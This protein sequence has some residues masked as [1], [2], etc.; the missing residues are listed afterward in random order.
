MEGGMIWYS[1][2]KRT[3]I[4]TMM[5]LMV[6]LT[7]HSATAAQNGHIYSHAHSKEQ[8]KPEVQLLN[9]SARATKPGMSSSA[10]YMTI[11]NGTHEAIQIRSLSSP[12]AAKT[13]LHTTEM[14]NGMMKMRR[15]DNLTIKPGDKLELK[16]GGYHVML[17][18][19]KKPIATNSEVPVTITFSNGDKKTVVAHATDEIKGQH[20]A[21]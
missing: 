2:I 10:A 8:S 7:A 16:P 5:V 15:V 12:V 9:A 13:E 11:Y 6:L 18:G 1:S 21:H 4:N 3:I 17:M 20:M 19:L 14:N